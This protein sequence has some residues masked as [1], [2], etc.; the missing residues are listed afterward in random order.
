MPYA[1]VTGATKGLGRA[2]AERLIVEGYTLIVCSRSQADL[3]DFQATFGARKI[4]T[5]VADLSNRD[6]VVHFA[7][8][9]L[10]T[11]EGA[12]E[13]LVNNAG[14]YLRGETIDTPDGELEHMVNTNLYS[15]YYL[16]N[17]L[18]P[19]LRQVK[20]A[21][22]FNICSVASVKILPHSGSY[23]VSKYALLG[24][25]KA[26]REELKPEGI[27]VTAVLPGG[28]WSESWAG[29]DLPRER[30]M[31]AS[32]IAEMIAA[33]LKLSPAAVIEEIVLRPQLG[34]V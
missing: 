11:S 8:F 10:K 13:I 7:Q 27:K 4:K 24:L 15:V 12:I 3:D 19:A 21:H 28:T 29:V 32:D 1:V 31:E 30:L 9:A 14:L 22:I 16:T 26:Q 5:C 23:C 33:A 6:Q 20:P 17:A 25:T 18:L 34:D 2:I